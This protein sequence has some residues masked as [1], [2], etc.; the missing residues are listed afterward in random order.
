MMKRVRWVAL[1]TAVVL[2]LGVVA[3]DAA[4]D[5]TLTILFDNTVYDERLEADW[6]FAALVEYGEHTI[7][8]DTGNSGSILLANMGTLGVDP[9]TI[10]II[11]LSHI[12][13]DHV[14]GLFALLDAGISPTVYVPDRFPQWFVERVGKRC[15]VVEVSD[16]V[17]IVPGVHSTGELVASPVEQ[18]LVIETV[19]GI[20]VVTGCA[21][22]GIVRIVER[23]KGVVDDEIKLV[24]G[25]FHLLQHGKTHVLR[26]IDDLRALGVRGACPTHC[27]GDDA[28]ALFAEEFGD[29]YVRG[30][31]GRIIHILGSLE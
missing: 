7:L 4:A 30:G 15:E 24:V 25:G 14:N 31:V 21:H 17:E 10:E 29:D 6:G 11:V 27:T 13:G 19:C 9:E 8:F 1:A 16:S 28:I 12:H 2:V 26:V 20:V 22:P 23:A 5:L 3:V 18:G